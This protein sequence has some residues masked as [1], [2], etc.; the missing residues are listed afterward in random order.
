[1]SFFYDLNK[2]LNGIRELPETTHKQ[3]NEGKPDFLDLDQDGNKK[4]PMKQ[5]AKQKPDYKSKMQD[6]FGGSAG[7]L[8]KGLSIKSKKVDEA[9]MS[10]AAKG[11]EKY[12]KDGMQALAKAGREGKALDPVR[13]KFD[14][15][16]ESMEEGNHSIRDVLAY[17]IEM[18]L[19][20]ADAGDDQ[21]D[22]I[23]DE[24]GDIFKDIKASR[25]K[26]A[27]MAYEMM[28][29]TIDED[30]TTQADA[31]R[32][33]LALL[34]NNS[35]SME[36]GSYSKDAMALNP[37]F[38]K[39]GKKPGVM[40]KIAK[41][42][43]KVAD[44][45]APGDEDL[46]RDLERKTGGRRPV[47]ENDQEGPAD[48]LAAVEEEMNNP[49]RTVDNLRDVL[50]ATFGSDRSPEFKKAR[51]VIGKY[52]DLI[53][54]AEVGSKE[55]GIA[56]MRG[57]NIA[58]HIREYDL[59]DRLAHAAAM[60][61]KVVG[62]KEAA[63]P[64]SAKQKSFAALAE[65]KDK[66]TF[67]DKIAGAKKEVDEMLGDV[68]A[69]AMKAALG[70]QQVR[71]MGEAT[72]EIPGGRRHTAEPGGYGRKDDEDAPRV[73][74]QRG[75]G[76]P[77]NRADSETGQVMKPD[78]SAFGVGG[79]VNLPKHKGAV[80]KHKMVG[81]ESDPQTWTTIEDVEFI[82]DL[83][84]RAF[85]A[86]SNS[87][88]NTL[89]G[90]LEVI[91]YNQDDEEPVN[92]KAVSKKQQR[93]MGMVHAAKKGEKPA[94]KEVAKAA[95]GISAKEADKFA[96]TKHKGLP[97]KVKA[98]DSDK[99]PAKKAKEEKVEETTTSGSVATAPAEGGKKSSGG[100][101]FGGGI[102]DSMNRDL[103][104]MIS[105]S[106]S[107]LD[108]SMN[109]SMNMNSDSHGGPTKSLTITATDDDADKLAMMLKMAGLGSD[110][111]HGESYSQA[112]DMVDENKPDW[113]TNTE[114]SNDAFQ[115]SGGINKPKT[116]V[117]GDGQSTGQ[118][119]AVSTVHKEDDEDDNLDEA[120]DSNM[121]DQVR[122]LVGDFD[123]NMTQ[124]RVY[125]DP[126]VDR[127]IAYLKQGDAEAAV[128]A[129]VDSYGDQNGGEFRNMS[130]YAKD[131]LSDFESLISSGQNDLDRMMEMAGVSG[132]QLDEGVMDKIKG[133]VPRFMQMV[134]ADTAAEIAK[135]VK[136]VT[137]GDYSLTRDNAIKVAKAF[138]FDKMQP[139][140]GQGQQQMAEGIAGNW[141]GKLLQLIHAGTIGGGIAHVAMGG[142]TI[143]GGLGAAGVVMAIVGGILLLFTETFW[144]SQ[145]GMIG[146]MGR[147]GNKGTST[148]RG[149]DPKGNIETTRYGNEE[150]DDYERR[151]QAMQKLGE[152]DLARMM[153]MAGVKK[154]KPDFLDMDKDGDKSEPMKKAV[155]DKK[156][157]AVK[158]SIFDL[159]NLWNTY[160]G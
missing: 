32:K 34:K 74:T 141:Q 127:A 52:L 47:K 20:G 24:L 143:G 58:R 96:S 103:E 43:K 146:S 46:L 66:I 80:T 70:K 126:D 22:H 160:K 105:E 136:Q 19:D 122:D 56:P 112:P 69:E 144:S 113:P 147:F 138:G 152:D 158:E 84:D 60:L 33:A 38:A 59:T 157:K 68:A 102:Y 114:T 117:A 26:A 151:L 18:I 86:G 156:E 107:R 109:I 142:G 111:N 116:D 71:G 93:F 44:F 53:D 30:A 41:G 89:Q 131:L 159:Q 15:Y 108:E 139:P 51:A 37:D 11:I 119:T 40:G 130:D 145:S 1:M 88:G 73:Q 100:F 118:V 64:M 99:K 150:E 12:G 83:M 10:R 63:A 55:D 45:V 42:V 153:E 36:E 57:G 61:D 120:A 140:G 6:K 75:R 13:N 25:D 23:I 149:L 7:D 91:K 9:G 14:K 94:S 3:L 98:K 48:L 21:T 123:R 128:E 85:E 39:V 90:V 148:Y 77:K 62:M 95:K 31:A 2:K 124:M 50:N 5:A 104:N 4:E 110:H 155:D 125:G 67:A 97:E 87:L 79:K 132:Q 65:P 35:A 133:I 72:K 28:V 76:R 27:M 101:N 137:G 54:N 82:Q 78:F 154:A 16:D 134:G 115:Y 49:G 17:E 121:A 106:M 81:E 129:V 92:E 8:T 29:D 135:Q